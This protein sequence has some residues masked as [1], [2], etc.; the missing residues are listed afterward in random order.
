MKVIRALWGDYHDESESRILRRR[1][2]IDSDVDRIISVSNLMPLSSF[3]CYVFGSNN[4]DMLEAKGF[5]CVKM[6]NEPYAFD[7]EK[8]TYRNKLECIRQAIYDINPIRLAEL[9]YL[10]WDCVPTRSYDF[11]VCSYQ[12]S[13]LTANL[14]YYRAIKCWWRDGD[15]R[16][17]PNAGYLHL[18]GRKVID[19]VIDCW[20]EIKDSGHESQNDEVA[21]ALWLDKKHKGWIGTDEY[22]EI[23]ETE[24]CQLKR[25]GVFKHDNAS[26]IHY[27]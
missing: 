10:D 21:I 18:M 6:S 14:M 4:F 23:Y 26:F 7:P 2:K 1:R 24:N 19:E 15:R 16:A 12:D 8:D 3:Q 25:K 20:Q 13:E 22:R 11:E 17:V 27:I 5:D 9:V